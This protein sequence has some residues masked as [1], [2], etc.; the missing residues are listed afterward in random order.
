MLTLLH[1]AVSR[2]MLSYGDEYYARSCFDTDND[3]EC[4]DCAR[5]RPTTTTEGVGCVFVD[6]KCARAT[7]CSRDPLNLTPTTTGDSSDRVL[8]PV[9]AQ[10]VDCA[11]SELADDHDHELLRQLQRQRQSQELARHGLPAQ[12]EHRRGTQH[13]SSARREHHRHAN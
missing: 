9:A 6:D 13:E 11:E 8:T 4:T 5:P 2:A 7:V 3:G 1:I 10:K 12:I